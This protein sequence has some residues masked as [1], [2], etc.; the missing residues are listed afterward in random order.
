LG[1]RSIGAGHG[2]FALALLI[3][4]P[5]QAEEPLCTAAGAG[6]VSCIAGRLC[7]CGF[8]R[9]SPANGLPDGFRWDCG[10]LRPSCG[11]PT[12][13]TLDPW[14]GELPS[15]LEIDRSNT[16]IQQGVVKPRGWP[17]H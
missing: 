2:A 13:A 4:S 12:P 16:I 7:S 3:G 10:I 17:R 8:A 15:S 1:K 11:S 14:Q 5:A 6:L 9:G